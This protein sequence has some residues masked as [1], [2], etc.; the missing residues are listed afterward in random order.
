MKPPF[1]LKWLACV[2]LMGCGSVH[3]AISCNVSS[4][5]FSSAYVP[6]NT[7]TN[8]T[9]ASLTMTCTRGASG[10]ATTQ[11]YTVKGNNGL[12]PSGGGANRAQSGINRI[13]YDTYINSGCATQW[14][15]NATIG[16]TITFTSTSDFA[17]RSDTQPFWGCIPA[18][19]NVPAGTY[20]DTVTMSPSIGSNA[21]FGVSIVTPS[22]CSISTPPGNIAFSYTAFQVG[23]A[24]ASTSFATNCTALLPYTMALDA[25]NGV[26]LGLQYSLSL[27]PASA[28]GNGSPQTYSI[29]GTIASGQPGT[30][31]TGACAASDPRQ[32]T[33]TY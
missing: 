9:T 22:S 13:S 4:N 2:A 32:I 6:A 1:D 21:T 23:T 24:S 17:S 26:L 25:T 16:G 14:K 33:I 10:D 29:N 20:T 27:S 3:A 31:A 12:S 15:N 11:S 18:S 5:G 28:V 8:I 30:C 7:A 19:Q